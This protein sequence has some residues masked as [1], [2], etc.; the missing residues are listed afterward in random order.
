MDQKLKVVLFT[1]RGY[2]LCQQLHTNPAGHRDIKEPVILASTS[3][4]MNNSVMILLKPQRPLKY[5][6]SR[7]HSPD[8]GTG[9]PGTPGPAPGSFPCLRARMHYRCRQGDGYFGWR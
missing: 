2:L 7:E 1:W 6:N 8:D 4:M 3:K 9:A 5:V